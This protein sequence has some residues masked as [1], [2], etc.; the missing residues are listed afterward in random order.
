[1]RSTGDSNG[2]RGAFQLS[3]KQVQEELGAA[4]ELPPELGEYMTTIQLHTGKLWFVAKA[5]VGCLRDP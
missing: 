1:M 3:L 2:G 5:R 4:K